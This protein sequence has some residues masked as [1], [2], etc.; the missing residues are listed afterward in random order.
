MEEMLLAPTTFDEFTPPDTLGPEQR[1]YLAVIERTILDYASTSKENRL[2][3]REAERFLESNDRAEFTVYWYGNVLSNR[4]EEFVAK[5]RVYAQNQRSKR[6][7]AKQA[8]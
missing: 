7:H 5:L 2:A 1:L 6:R 8:A 4:P 3:R